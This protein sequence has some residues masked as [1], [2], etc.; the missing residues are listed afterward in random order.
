VVTKYARTA[1]GGKPERC[2]Q[3]ITIKGGQWFQVFAL[4]WD[5]N[6]DT[7]A[8]QLQQMAHIIVVAD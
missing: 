6:W 4:T 5:A 2:L 8:A 3:V 7:Q 1:G